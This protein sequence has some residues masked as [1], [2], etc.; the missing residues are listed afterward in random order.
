MDFAGPLSQN[1]AYQWDALL[2]ALQDSHINKSNDFVSWVLEK[3]GRY[4][5][6]S[7]Y[8][9]ILHREVLNIRMRKMWKSKLP[10]KLKIFMWL[11]FQGR[12]QAGV[13][14]GGMKWK[15]DTRCVVCGVPETSGKTSLGRD[16]GGLLL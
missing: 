9:Y 3:S 15:G 11:V 16:Q 13:V 7:M 5:T 1:E 10:M 6:K 8:R 12:V 4:T 14:L 2:G